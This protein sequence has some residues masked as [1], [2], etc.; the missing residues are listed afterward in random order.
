MTAAARTPL[1][2]ARRWAVALAAPL[3]Q[4]N[5]FPLD[6][7]GGW[8]RRGGLGDPAARELLRELAQIDGRADALEG[9]PRRLE[10]G[11]G[12]E[13]DR[14][15]AW[16][17]ALPREFQAMGFHALDPVEYR[18]RLFA[19]DHVGAPEEANPVALD[20]AR[21]VTFAG[22]AYRAAYLA[23]HEAWAQVARA[24]AMA[25]GA[26]TSWEAFGRGLAYARW[27]SA[28]YVDPNTQ[29]METC[30]AALL[31]DPSSP[32][33]TLPWDLDLS[34]LDTLAS[35]PGDPG[36]PLLALGVRLVVDCPECLA[37]TLLRTASP[38]A[39]CQACCA[40]IDGATAH[41]WATATRLADQVEVDQAQDDEEAPVAGPMA[42]GLLHLQNLGDN[43]EDI[44]YVRAPPTCECGSVLADAAIRAAMPSG[45]LRCACGR[46]IPIALAP[47][48]VRAVDWRARYVVGG[49]LRVG[50]PGGLITLLFSEG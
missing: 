17:Q 29:A 48:A 15:R 35:D 11:F 16:R 13:Y 26:Y 38:A 20:V 24:A 31:S 46:A 5:Q 8:P 9:L 21:L 18:V 49:P 39:T 32:W 37:P 41:A 27:F 7:L 1:E 22:L 33:S 14:A 44:A 40:R 45:T 4:Q 47:A 43:L 6:T 30:V 12:A 28:G 23:E 42:D 34:P 2:A 50:A 3:H 19:L 25:R 10:E 36:G